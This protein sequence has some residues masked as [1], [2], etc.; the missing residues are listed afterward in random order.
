MQNH[1]MFRV[2]NVEGAW[3]DCSFFSHSRHCPDYM[4]MLHRHCRDD[5]QQR[6]RWQRE[7]EELA[8]D[9]ARAERDALQTEALDLAED[10]REYLRREKVL[11]KELRKAL[12]ER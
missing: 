5:M 2:W 6:L 7:S 11:L 12:L 4:F 8:A 9:H 10:W 3:N 1:A